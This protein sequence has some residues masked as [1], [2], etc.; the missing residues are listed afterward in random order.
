[1]PYD[2]SQVKVLIVDDM[3]A[4]LALT[5]S[6]LKNFGFKSVDGARSAEDGYELFK[7]HN[8]DIVI[9]DWLMEPMDGLELIKMIRRGEDSP[10]K[11]VPIILM[12]GY[13]DK[14]RVMT[15]RDQGTTEFL[16][17]PYTVRDM[18]ARI[19]QIIEKPRQFV[20]AS[21][22]FGPDRRRKRIF[23]YSGADKRDIGE[24]NADSWPNKIVN[25]EDAS[26]TDDA[27][28]T[29]QEETKKL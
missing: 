1:M 27:L 2:L 9:T 11:F 19:T 16:M 3:Q 4:M 18:Y 20:E 17:K 26:S 23:E 8:H 14:P 5:V 29:L 24:K 21:E 12:T 15:A 13:S 10:N 7:Q 25:E 22:F 6:L 28:R